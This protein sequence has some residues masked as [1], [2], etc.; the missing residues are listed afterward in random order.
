MTSNSRLSWIAL[1]FG[2]ALTLLIALAFV[3][4]T[5]RALMWTSSGLRHQFGIMLGEVTWTRRPEGWRLE[6]ERY[7][8]APGWAVASYGHGGYPLHCWTSAGANKSWQWFS[9]PFWMPFTIVAPATVLLWYGKRRAVAR[10]FRQALTWLAPRYPCHLRFWLVTTFCFVHILAI[11][12]AWSAWD[13]VYDFF[14]AY[15]SYRPDDPVPA[16]ISVIV[17]ILFFGTPVL[18]VF[19]A[20]LGVGL[21]SHLF[22]RHAGNRC[23]NRGYDLT[24]NVSGRCPECG[25]PLPAA[26][27]PTKL[28]AL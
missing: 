1:Y 20:W 27:P 2:T 17:R 14:S 22:R 19:W 4:S 18:A 25:V 10:S 23:L 9:I 12:L 3:W 7:P 11:F 21:R 8:A 16:G 28:S 26:P 13:Y 24:G 6:D 15:R 5:R